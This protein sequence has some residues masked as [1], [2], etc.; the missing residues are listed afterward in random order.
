MPTYGVNAVTT[1]AVEALTNIFDKEMGKRKMIVNAVAPGPMA[2]AL[3]FDD[4]DDESIVQIA[5]MA[6]LGLFGEP[7]DIAVA[8]PTGADGACVD[9]GVI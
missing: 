1:A 6:P 2:T 3:S 9:G 8:V 7:V 5:S 4:K